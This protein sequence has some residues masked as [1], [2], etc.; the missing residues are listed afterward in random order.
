M[1]S[2]CVQATY[3]NPLSHEGQQSNMRF[4]NP[5]TLTHQQQGA[6]YDYNQYLLKRQ[7]QERRFSYASM[8]SDSDACY[9]P[10]I[11]N[12]SPSTNHS[13]D[14]FHHHHQQQQEGIVSPSPSA[15]A[16]FYVDCHTTKHHAMPLEQH[17]RLPYYDATNYSQ[18]YH[19]QT[20]NS[21]YPSM[22]SPPASTFLSKQQSRP[23]TPV[24]PPLLVKDSSN[25]Y[26]YQQQEEDSTKQQQVKKA[27]RSRG[28]RVSNVPG[29]GARMFTCKAD[30]CGKVFKRSE[31]LKRHIRSI[32]TLEKRKCYL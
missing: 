24:S 27:P 9:L 31:H 26:N 6:S 2:S 19:S 13:S 32:H 17:Q 11:T 12:S 29:C 4:V 20:T 21:N 8:L 16:T 18:Y 15:N 5:N 22:I 23:M 25:N 3:Q 28:R 30:G 7:Q 1:S 10:T 14:D